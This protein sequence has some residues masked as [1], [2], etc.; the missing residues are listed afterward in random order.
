VQL[1]RYGLVL[2]CGAVAGS[3]TVDALRAWQEWHRW[4]NQDPSGAEAYRTFFTVNSAIA[5]GS[6]AL[7]ALLWYLLRDR[8]A[9]PTGQRR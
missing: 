4:L 9:R 5:L 7:A 1:I 2:L 3:R 6:L 8:R